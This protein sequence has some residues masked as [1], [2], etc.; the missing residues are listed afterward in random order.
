MK[1]V[2]Y[3]AQDKVEGLVS[4]ASSARKSDETCKTFPREHCLHG[5]IS[6]LSELLY[7]SI[8]TYA[9]MN[10]WVS[11]RVMICSPYYASSCG[12]LS[13]ANLFAAIWSMAASS[14]Q[15]LFPLWMQI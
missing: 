13:E 8:V 6:K 7:L 9:R 10:P 11:D 15:H 5:M 14:N 1:L 4:M 12:N 3:R 2:Y